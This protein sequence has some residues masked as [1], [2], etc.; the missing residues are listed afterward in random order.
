MNIDPT[1][2]PGGWS[3]DALLAKGQLYVEQMQAF[4]HDDWRF[5]LWSTLALELL[6]RATLA[7]ISP[8]LLADPKDWNNTLHALGMAPKAAKFVPRSVD[9]SQV[10]VRLQEIVPG[11]TPEIGGFAQAHISR[12]NEEL[13]SGSSP[14][15]GLKS[16]SWLPLYYRTCQV[17]LTS[18]G[19]TLENFVGQRT[20]QI[21]IEMIAASLD[22]SAKAVAK[23]I[24]AHGAVW[25]AKEAAE[26]L[27]LARQASIWAT[28][29]TGHRVKCP[30]CGCDALLSGAPIDAPIRTIDGDEITEV[31]QKL[32]SKFECI[33]C[34]IK[35]S[36]LPQLAACGFGDAF[37]TTSI[38]DAADYY[39][40]D[41]DYSGYEPDN[42]EP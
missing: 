25:G 2:V 20:A 5:V 21:A 18:I 3:K 26:R 11:F 6:A 30:A 15:D 36:G 28:K 12:R 35:I 42:N 38:Y 17:L 40:Q 34:G 32:P 31:Q 29:Q 23:A 1:Q 14:L 7:H 27:L 19:E 16:S 8:T 4:A 24:G 37:K 13:H 41:D 22:D 10:I 9:I 39:A 33:A